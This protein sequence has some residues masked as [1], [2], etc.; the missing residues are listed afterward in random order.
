MQKEFVVLNFKRFRP[1]LVANAPLQRLYSGRY[2]GGRA[3]LFR[4]PR[5]ASVQRRSGRKD[6]PLRRR[7]GADRFPAAFRQRKRQRARS[8][9]TPSDL[10]ER[11]P[12]GH[13][14]GIRR[15]DH[16]SR[17]TLRGQAP[18]FAERHRRQLRRRRSGSRIPITESSATTRETRRRARSG[19]DAFFASTRRAAV[20]RSQPTS[21]ANRTASPSRPTKRSCT[22]P[23]RA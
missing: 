7:P 16:G 2:V 5:R 18:Q 6:S 23:T 3:G 22:S 8:P 1:Y 10:R 4:G 21:S 12:P 17:R 11:Q 14:H 9:G 20:S 19:G 15:K 13:T